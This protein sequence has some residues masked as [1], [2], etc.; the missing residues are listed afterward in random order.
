M[1]PVIFLDFDGP[2]IPDRAFYHPKNSQVIPQLFDPYAI[3]MIQWCAEKVDAQYV[4]SSSWRDFGR[5]RVV[6]T[7]EENGV[8][9]R[10]LHPDWATPRYG[11]GSL[12]TRTEEIL[13]WLREHPEVTTWAAIDDMGDQKKL[14]GLIKVTKED[15]FLLRHFL[16]LRTLLNVPGRLEDEI[17]FP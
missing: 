7:L 11:Q 3:G 13:L 9:T 8:D 4:I 17:L 16:K 6:D 1:R 10:R 2:L 15:G 14:P 5:H 12:A